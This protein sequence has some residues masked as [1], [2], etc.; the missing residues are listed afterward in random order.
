MHTYRS[1]TMKV[2]FQTEEKNVFVCGYMS[3]VLMDFHL[4][5]LHAKSECQDFSLLL[6]ISVDH[7]TH[8]KISRA[9]LACVNEIMIKLKLKA[10]RKD[11][12]LEKNWCQ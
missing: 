2:M 9:F 3:R 10:Q 1:V 7:S 12:N 5:F 6:F 4:T 8:R 11:H